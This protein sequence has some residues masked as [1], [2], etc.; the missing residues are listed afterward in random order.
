METAASHFWEPQEFVLRKQMVQAANGNASSLMQC[1]PGIYAM[2]RMD[3]DKDQSKTV[4][5]WLDNL[6]F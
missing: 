1:L 6:G 3:I 4:R 2:Y 5:K